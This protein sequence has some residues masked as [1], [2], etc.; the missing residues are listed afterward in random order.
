MLQVLVSLC[1]HECPAKLLKHAEA[2]LVEFT[3]RPDWDF[4]S[5]TL[6]RESGEGI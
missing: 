3:D 4:D 1:M 6:G 2:F 5:T